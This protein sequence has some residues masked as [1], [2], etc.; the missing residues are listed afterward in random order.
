MG[1][2]A[3]RKPL[4]KANSNRSPRLVREPLE[5]REQPR[6]RANI[7]ENAGHRGACSLVFAA[8]RGSGDR[9]G[10]AGGAKRDRKRTAA[11]RERMRDNHG[12]GRESRACAP[13]V[14]CLDTGWPV[15]TVVVVVPDHR[16][17]RCGIEAEPAALEGS[18]VH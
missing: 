8:V 4:R 10:T 18:I 6:T 7:P 15:R 11:V 3:P 16:R 12:T 17:G 13:G 2:Q 1:P 14:G 9:N 5:N